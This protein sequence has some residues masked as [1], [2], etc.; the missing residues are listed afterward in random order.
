ML[1]IKD[2]N[3][4]VMGVLKDEDTE[5]TIITCKICEGEGWDFK[6]KKPPYSK[7]ICKKEKETKNADI[8]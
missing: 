1:K 4:K 6:N 5:P 7:C 3:G 8:C 2:K